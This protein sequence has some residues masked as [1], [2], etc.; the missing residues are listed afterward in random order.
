MIL[1]LVYEA[2]ENLLNNT[3]RKC[4]AEMRP[5]KWEKDAE[6]RKDVFLKLNSE[7]VQPHLKKIEEQLI[8]NGTGFLVGDSV[9]ILLILFS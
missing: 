9:C 6:K 5:V 8:K 4:S 3:L 2:F 1:Y 7:K